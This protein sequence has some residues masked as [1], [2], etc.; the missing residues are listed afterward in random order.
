MPIEAINEF[1][2]ENGK[3]KWDWEAPAEDEELTAAVAAAAKSGLSDAY[4]ISDK[5]ERQAAV[6][7]A[8]SAAVEALA[9]AED[10]RWSAEEVYGALSKLEKNIVRDRV[11]AG[12]P[13]IDG[14]DTKTVRPIDVKIG[15]LPRAHGSAIAA[16]DRAA[17]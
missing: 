7:D 11:I 17:E 16:R 8:K 15:L 9:G 12:E 2:A 10:A 13:R 4:R 14:R 6:G 3:P 1:A 5:V